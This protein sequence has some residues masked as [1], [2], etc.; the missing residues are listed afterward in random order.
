MF[1]ARYGIYV[2]LFLMC[3]GGLLISSRFLTTTNF[4]SIALSVGYTGFTATGMAFVVISGSLIDLSIPGVI[5]AAGLIA[6]AAE[7]TVGAV[8]AIL[9]ALGAGCFVGLV[10][11]VAI[12]YLRVNP[13][14]ATYA[15][16][17]V[18]LGILR[19]SLAAA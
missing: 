18:A 15:A 11:G 5:A 9:I 2:A 7:P 17:I 13:V 4:L 1:L 6:L 19:R 10:N 3:V 14:L 12:G 8:P 16:Q